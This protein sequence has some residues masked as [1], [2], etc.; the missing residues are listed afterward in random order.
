M[1]Y[2][3]TKL[4]GGREED[5]QEDQSL[6]AGRQTPDGL[7]SFHGTPPILFK[8]PWTGDNNAHLML[9]NGRPGQAT[10]VQKEAPLI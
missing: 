2:W 1:T 7:F 9:G 8:C 6:V 3:P 4:G 5:E 10:R